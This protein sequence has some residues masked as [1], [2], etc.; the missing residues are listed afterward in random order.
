MAAA[1]DPPRHTELAW[2]RGGWARCF[3]GSAVGGR[4]RGSV[5][6]SRGTSAK[7]LGEQ[8][9]GAPSLLPSSPQ[10]GKSACLEPSRWAFFRRARVP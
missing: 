10:E 4:F 8:P 9:F 5:A 1:R 2:K 7:A 3:R 6:G